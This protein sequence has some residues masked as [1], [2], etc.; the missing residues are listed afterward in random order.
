LGPSARVSD[1]R[2]IIMS[3][4]VGKKE[5]RLRS[6][7]CGKPMIREGSRTSI[8]C[9]SKFSR[10]VGLGGWNVHHG[11]QKHANQMPL[12]S[13]RWHPL[14]PSPQSERSRYV[15]AFPP[16]RHPQQPVMMI[17]GLGSEGNTFGIGSDGQG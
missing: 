4:A 5:D 13:Q 17:H 3:A 12:S 15:G 1:C 2:P 9:S 8:A 10:P 11:R 6:T 16:P 14:S 7:R